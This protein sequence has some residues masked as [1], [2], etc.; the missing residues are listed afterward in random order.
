MPAKKKPQLI[1]EKS[2]HM[3]IY[4]KNQNKTELQ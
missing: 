1:C 3:I 2:N 4:L